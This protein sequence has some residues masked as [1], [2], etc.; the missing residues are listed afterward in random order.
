MDGSCYFENDPWVLAESK[1]RQ[2]ESL[3][4]I[5]E[6][7]IQCV[8]QGKQADQYRVKW[9][10]RVQK[11]LGDPVTTDLIHSER[12]LS[13]LLVYPNGSIVR[14]FMDQGNMDFSENF[15]IVTKKSLYL[16]HP[17]SNPQG[18]YET[19]SDISCVCQQ[20]YSTDLEVHES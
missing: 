10:K 8:C 16:W 6:V 19:L 9:E 14:M 1:I 15:E 18:Y 7:N 20:L 2:E 5:V 17:D 13:Q 3:D 4:D 11:L 12:A